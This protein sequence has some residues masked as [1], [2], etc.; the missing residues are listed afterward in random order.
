MR[1]FFRSGLAKVGKVGQVLPHPGDAGNRLTPA[2]NATRDEPVS[3]SEVKIV[4]SVIPG[5]MGQAPIP[6]RRTRSGELHIVRDDIAGLLAH[7][8]RT[9]LSAIAMNLDFVLG[10]LE[11]TEAESVRAALEDCRQANVR[12]VR[13]VSDMADALQLATGERRVT[14]SEVDGAEIVGEVVRRVVAEAAARNIEVGWTAHGET[15]RADA[16]LLTRAVE[17]IVQRALG[18]ARSGGRVDIVLNSGTVTVRVSGPPLVG[19][20]VPPRSLAT[21]FAEA[22]LRAQGGAMWTEKDVDGALVYRVQLPA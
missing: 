15:F 16:D 10:E 2:L 8:L 19:T 4:T 21:H 14:L 9:P 12:A 7:D 17:R 11:G 18:H 3:E 22:A 20:E 6:R 13:L 1:M 5:P